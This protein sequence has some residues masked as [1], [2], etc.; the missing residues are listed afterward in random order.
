MSF[1][2]LMYTLSL[3]PPEQLHIANPVLRLKIVEEQTP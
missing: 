3:A 2:V 1:F